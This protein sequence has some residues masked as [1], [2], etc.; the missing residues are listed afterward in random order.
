ME[1]KITVFVDEKPKQLFLGLRVRHAIGPRKAK[2]VEQRRMV[3]RDADGNII[4]VDGALHDGQ[5]LYLVKTG[6]ED[7]TPAV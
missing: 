4:D 2:A 3:V 5:R 7:V 6:P 1:E